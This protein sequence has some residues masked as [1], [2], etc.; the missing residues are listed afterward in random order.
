MF[1][2]APAQVA[3]TPPQTL[4]FLPVACCSHVTVDYLLDVHEVVA[5]QEA[6]VHCF[7]DITHSSLTLVHQFKTLEPGEDLTVTWHHMTPRGSQTASVVS[8]RWREMAF[9]PLWAGLHLCTL[10]P[11]GDV[12]QVWACCV[13]VPP[14]PRILLF[15]RFRFFPCCEWTSSFCSPP[16]VWDS[17]HQFPGSRCAS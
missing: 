2:C 5:Q 7:S 11:S 9:P 14:V 17:L 12:F 4:C 15:V 16:A 6:V 13:Q 8:S 10:T 1:L 3:F